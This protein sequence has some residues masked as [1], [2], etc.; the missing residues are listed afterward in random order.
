MPRLSALFFASLV[1]GCSLSHSDGGV[2]C[3]PTVCAAGTVCCNES[4]GICVAPGEGCIE[5]AC[6]DAGGPAHC[7]SDRCGPGEECCVDCDGAPYCHAGSCP[8]L[9]CPLPDC[10][11][12]GLGERCCPT[13]PGSAP[14]CVGG[15]VCPEV[16]CPSPPSGCESCAPGAPCC[17]SCPGA[18]WFCGEPGLACPSIEMC[19]SPTPCDDARRCDDEHY[20]DRESCGGEGVCVPRPRECTE[21]CPGACGCDGETYCNACEAAA[22]GVD[23]AHTGACETTCAGR[24]YCDC[25]GSCEPLIDLSTGCICPC[26]DPFNCTGEPC[27]CGCGGATYLGCAAL[28]RCAQTEVDC[29]P[30]CRASLDAA[31]CPV[32]ACEG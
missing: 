2:R 10:E 30:G 15:A 21:D 4:C 5:L 28:G 20:C 29:G 9:R 3:G 12:C 18:A 14:V 13:C 31:G 32:C 24:D 17:P 1:A 8:L 27:D 26:D 7:G 19:P 22:A 11:E 16:D 6:V 23:V 25:T